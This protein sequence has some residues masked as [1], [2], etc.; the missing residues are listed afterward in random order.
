M[1]IHTEKAFIVPLSYGLALYKE[2]NWPVC[3]FCSIKWIECSNNI[4]L[5]FFFVIL[6]NNSKISYRVCDE[7][8]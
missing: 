5:L 4:S 2:V 6:V 8:Q 7:S 3:F 1:F